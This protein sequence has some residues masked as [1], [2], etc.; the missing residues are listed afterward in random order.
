MVLKHKKLKYNARIQNSGYLLK[1]GSLAVICRTPD[2]SSLLLM[3]HCVMWFYVLWNSYM[4]MI[5]QFKKF[6][7][8]NKY[9]HVEFLK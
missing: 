6:F 3:I 5:L 9:K 2:G 1:E 8:R 4:C 7:K